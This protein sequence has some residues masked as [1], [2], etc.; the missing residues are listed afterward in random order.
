[1]TADGNG[2]APGAG[3]YE[4]ERAD[5]EEPVGGPVAEAAGVDVPEDEES[6]AAEGAAA[7]GADEAEAAAEGTAPAEGEAPAT[8]EPEAPTGPKRRELRLT[9]RLKP[10]ADKTLA[11]MGVS[12]PETDI[13]ATAVPL[14]GATTDAEALSLALEQVSA[15]VAE[16]EVRWAGQ[17]RYEQY[18]RP[19]PPR[20]AAVKTPA[21]T[22]KPSVSP[23]LQRPVA[24]AAP[25]PEVTNTA[26]GAGS[27]A[28]GPA[29]MAPAATAVATV[30]TPLKP[31]SGTKTPDA[32]QPALF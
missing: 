3:V 27:D 25:E 20:T 28:T 17:P 14:E 11:V 13:V 19:T 16:A 30:P 23:T 18:K 8:V 6:A 1:M 12:S 22:A 29:D 10:K 15:L 31:V 2:A 5:E 4:R 26:D 9:I 32:A 21:K 24:D 7:D